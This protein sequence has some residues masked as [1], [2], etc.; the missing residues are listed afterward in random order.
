MNIDPLS[1][2]GGPVNGAN[3]FTHR[4]EETQSQ[5]AAKRDTISIE[6]SMRIDSAMDQI[7][8]IRP[9]VVERGRQL[10][11]DPNYPSPDLAQKIASLIVPFDESV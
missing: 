3:G 1:S 2:S 6:R 7:P 4:N 5:H 9:E 10:L 11:A 8:E